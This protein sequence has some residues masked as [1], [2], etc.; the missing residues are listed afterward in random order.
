MLFKANR[1][2]LPTK[3]DNHLPFLCF[4]PRVRLLNIFLLLNSAVS[5]VISKQLA[6]HVLQ[7]S[8][9]TVKSANKM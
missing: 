8:T 1:E 7:L 2:Q 5:R 4:S 9:H 3:A 6:E